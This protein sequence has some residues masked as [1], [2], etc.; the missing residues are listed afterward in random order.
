MPSNRVD[1]VNKDD[2][3][4][5]LLALLEKV[6]DATRTHADEHFDKIRTRDGEERNIGF[7]GNRTGQQSLT[8]SRRSYQQ[9]A[10]GNASAQFLEFLRL[11]QEFDDLFQLFLG[12]IDASHVLERDLLLLH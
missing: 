2:A 4:S 5:I 3:R 6:S 11:A 12:F 9:H 7:A 10:L 8:C 1:L